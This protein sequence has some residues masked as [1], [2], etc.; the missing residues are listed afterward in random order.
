MDRW[1]VVISILSPNY[2]SG[3]SII[4]VGVIGCGHWGPNH[5]RVFAQLPGSRTVACAD[6]D[7]NR[8]AAITTLY[9][10]V[11]AFES[12]QEMLTQGGVD[13]VVVAVPT[14][15]HHAVVKECLEAGKHILCEKPLCIEPFE[16]DDLAQ[17]A[18]RV[19]KILMVGHVFLFNAGIRK[20]KELTRSEGMGRVNYLRATR[21]NLGPIRSDV[22]SVYDLATHDIS[23]FNWILDCEPE[24][25]SAVG[26][27]FLQSGIE[28][29]A[30][31]SL[32]YPGNI[33]AN[34]QVSWLDPKKLRE[35]VVV[36]EK[37]MLVWDDLASPGPVSIYDK[38]V[39][40]PPDYQ[41]FGQ[42]HLV[43]REG[44]LT[45]PKVR[46]EEPLK[47][48]NR[49]FLEAIRSGRLLENDSRF[50]VGVV[51]TLRAI[52]RSIKQGG[53]AVALDPA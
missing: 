53:A 42:F 40:R 44:D 10:Q 28:D 3:S 51:R 31:I 45:I 52:D 48:Q 21:T 6:P 23:I 20:L 32:R 24:S 18:A 46:L 30:F 39:D 49:F 35:I 29:V 4:S 36:S 13:A 26:G 33:L 12:F 7:A 27:C 47:A 14:R 43:A 5:V 22:N 17:C 11:R 2:M 50:T 37:K 15:L 8:R 38:G 19:G 16:A 1:A 25:A 9:P 41:D 34:I